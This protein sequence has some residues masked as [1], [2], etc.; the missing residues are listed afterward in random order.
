[1]SFFIIVQFFDTI[2][3]IEGQNFIRNTEQSLKILP[4]ALKRSQ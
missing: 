4:R 2:C 1:M 3:E